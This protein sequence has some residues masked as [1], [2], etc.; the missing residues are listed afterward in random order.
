MAK[1]TI[2]QLEAEIKAEKAKIRVHEGEEKAKRKLKEAKTELFL[3][4]HK[5]QIEA[6]EKA[7]RNIRTGAKAGAKGVS[8]LAKALSRGLTALQ[9]Y[10][11][12]VEAKEAKE[13]RKNR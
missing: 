10:E 6:V 8:A 5:R 4:K 9:D 12:K 2:A 1:K 7:T 11:Q 3:L 13:A